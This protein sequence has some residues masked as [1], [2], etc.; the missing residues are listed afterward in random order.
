ENFGDRGA[1]RA[2]GRQVI[3]GHAN[4][5]AALARSLYEADRAG[6]FHIGGADGTPRNQFIGPFFDNFSVPLQLDPSRPFNEPMRMLIVDFANVIHMSQNA[7]QVLE[8]AEEAIHFVYW[9]IDRDRTID[10]DSQLM[11]H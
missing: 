8:V 9:S 7:P 10:A 3:E 5:R 6:A 2:C 11:R 4:K 1:Q